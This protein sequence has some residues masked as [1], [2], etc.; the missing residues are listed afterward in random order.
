MSD[1]RW[2]YCKALIVGL[3]LVWIAAGCS[4]RGTEYTYGEAV[5]DAI[6]ILILESFPVQIRAVLRGFVPD[7]CTEVVSVTAEFEGNVFTLSVGTRRP[8]DAICIQ[9]LTSYEVMASLDVLGLPAGTYTVVAGEASATF[10]LAVDN[11]PQD[12]P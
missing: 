4:P 9:V 12:G 3:L 5:V 7:P 6:D 8:T 2:R 10:E 11:T 1:R